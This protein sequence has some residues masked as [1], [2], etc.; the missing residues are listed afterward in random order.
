MT[1]KNKGRKG[2]NHLIKARGE[3]ILRLLKRAAGKKN[4]RRRRA[5]K[6]IIRA[7]TLA[8]VIFVISLFIALSKIDLDAFRED[9]T[10]GIRAAT[11]LSVEIRG[12]VAWR[13]SL[14]P[15]ATLSD[16]RI[17]NADWAKNPD[18]VLVESAVVTLNLLSLF[19][20]QPAAMELRL[21]NMRMFLEENEN[22]NL[23]IETDRES[24]SANVSAEADDRFPFDLNFGLETIELVNPRIT[25]EHPSGTEEWSLSHA[26][27]GYKRHEDA[28]EYSGSIEKDRSET[29]FIVTFSE[30]DAGRKVYPVRIAVAGRP[31]RLVAHGALEMTSKIPIDFIITG[32]VYDI[33]R[34][35]AIL[36][37]D[38][39]EI[40]KFDLDISGG[41]DH[42]KLVVRKSEFKS[43]GNDL[44]VSGEFNWKGIKPSVTASVRSDNI[45]LKQVAPDIYRP[46]N[47][48]WVRP[49]GRE[50]NVF[51]DTPLYPELAWLA[52]VD[53]SLDVRNLVVY[54]ELA[55]REIIARAVLKDGEASVRAIAEMGGG[56]IIGSVQAREEDGIL[57]ARAAGR[58]HD[59][60]VGDLLTEL[61]THNFLTGLPGGFEFAFETSGRDLSGFMSNIN[62]RIVGASTGKGRALRDARDYL[63]GKD[64]L[65]VLRDNVTNVVRKNTEE[66]I[67]INC[68]ALNL[69]I[70]DGRAETERGVAVETS[71]VNIRAQGYAD[72]GRETLQASIVATPVR[73]LKLSVSGNVVNSMEFT[74]NMA[75]PDL[76]INRSAVVNKAVTATGIGL[77]LAPFTGGLSIA[78]GAGIGLLSSDLLTNWLADDHPCQTALSDKGAP[79]RKD[80]PEFMNRRLNE[81][82][83]EMLF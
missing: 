27:I 45:N 77:I 15:R 29:S 47:P 13:L 21:V 36:N 7:F 16:V 58:G 69:R 76:K 68:A 41:M 11:G 64:S 30:L 57:H 23:S 61:R 59:I 10:S 25:Y 32:T 63:Y 80:D 54:R 78:A 6:F 72:L 31:M 4:S 81:V 56:E 62:G 52:N 73:G 35:G 82:V 17:A 33:K 20:G 49:V 8:F 1:K 34:V 26:R 39:P 19:S 5:A 48:P 79:G 22:G 38:F 46:E 71:E 66:V 28:V 24:E 75:E 50:L 83:D 42:S 12:N 14:R 43:G 37:M 3:K 9:I 44:H 40:P 67:R 2:H 60:V 53:L 18:G 65:T 55:V 51:K 74:G 70:R